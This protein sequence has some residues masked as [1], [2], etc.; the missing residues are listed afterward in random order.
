[1][2]YLFDR[3]QEYKNANIYPFHMPG[4][5]RNIYKGQDFFSYD[6]TEIPGFDDLHH[7]EEILK[8][9]MNRAA[10]LYGAEKTFYLVNGSTVGILAAINSVY[11]QSK[12]KGK[13]LLS[14]NS[15]KSA[16]NALLLSGMDAEY[17]YP[18]YLEDFHLN[19]GINPQDIED[20]LKKN[21]LAESNKIA[22]VFI[23]S[24][25]YDGIVS[26]I[27]KIVKIA[28][29]YNV[30]VIVD[31]AH[32][33]HFAWEEDIESA[34]SCGADIVINSLHKTLPCM[35]QTALLHVSGKYIDISVIK[36]SLQILQTSSPSYILM[37]S[38]DEC[39]RY[40][41]KNGKEFCENRVQLRKLFDYLTQNLQKLRVVTRDIVGKSHVHGYDLGKII[42][43]AINTNIS[44]EQLS[45]RLR[46]E[47]GIQ[48][49]MS[50]PD[51]VLGILTGADT[52]EGIE[53]LV[54]ALCCIDTEIDFVQNGD[55]RYTSAYCN[56]KVLPVSSVNYT[57]K[58]RVKLEEASGSVSCEYVYAY[59]PGIPVIVPG[60]RI[61]EDIVKFI[62]EYGELGLSVR[63]LSDETNQTIL[64]TEK[65]V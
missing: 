19:G 33:A 9:S 13:L 49:E 12:K 41:G 53:R 45:E 55:T 2:E 43:S 40:M 51:Y 44:G 64:V 18:S 42:V 34:V 10:D 7:P 39:I 31:E 21:K 28:H 50:S 38:I 11:V 23:T 22:A 4:H 6:I 29:E 56:E 15:H 48:M 60:E 35:T 32:G 17:I 65:I 36:Q 14:R 47:H 30:P 62:K 58:K 37:S 52:K 54:N 24:P 3:L 26:D 59:P 61:S 63:G 16:Y 20:V 46:V 27:K 5:K 1:M 25:T 8:A 57:N